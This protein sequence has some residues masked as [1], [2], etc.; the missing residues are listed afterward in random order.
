MS[1]ASLW[2]PY[3]Q[4][5]NLPAPFQVESARG[6]R[7]R[8]NDGRELIDAVSSWWCV[9]HGYNHPE[10]N[11]ALT[12]QLE[13]CAHVMLGG[14]THEPARQAAE[15]L[16]RITPA[17]LEHV[18]FSDSGSVGV[19]VALKMALQYWL[20]R[21]V[22]GKHKFLALRKAYHGDTIGAMSVCDPDDGMHALFAPLLPAQVFMDPPRTPPERAL[23]SGD[24]DAMLAADLDRL[25]TLL[26]RHAAEIAALILEPTA[27]L[28]GGFVFYSPEFLRAA[29]A[30]CDRHEVLM[31]FD[32]VATG[33]GR[34]GAL[35]AA[36]RSGISPDIMVLGKALT[37]GYL[38]HAATLAS[39]R[40]FE[41]FYDDDAGRAF[42]HGP[43]FMANPLACAL[44]LK[45]Y[46]IFEREKTLAR[47]ARIE[48]ILREELLG[49]ESRALENARV[50]GAIGVLELKAA[51]LTRGAQAFAAERGVWL[52]PFDQFVYTMPPYVI[53]EDDLRRVCAA[54]RDFVESVG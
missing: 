44:M 25:E 34:T 49:I 32:E 31:I 43:T 20:N 27:M 50:F 12:A 21:G 6:V 16:A 15:L 54:M 37:G 41:A 22:S 18:F 14:L 42:M 3:A 23:A 47:V 38:G 48:T 30:I 1:S 19:E 11:A 53:A 36:D 51:A 24:Y 10:L 46:E 40:V 9:I 17:G 35:F 33:F 13:R 7:L 39:D 26:R 8:M 4:M 45:S 52:R 29:R 5:R 28:A 2:F